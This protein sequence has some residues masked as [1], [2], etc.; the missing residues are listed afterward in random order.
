MNGNKASARTL[1]IEMS[2]ETKVAAE[3]PTVDALLEQIS[4]VEYVN[5]PYVMSPTS[6]WE[7]LR[8]FGQTEFDIRVVLYR[9]R[10]GWCPY[11]HKVR[12]HSFSFLYLTPTCIMFLY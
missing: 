2:D 11:C 6:E 9:D 1:T 5:G 10:A 4:P 3:V 12:F 7:S 8:L